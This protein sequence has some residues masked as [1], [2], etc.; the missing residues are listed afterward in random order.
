M[1]DIKCRICGEP[2][3]SYGV[4][5]SLRID[6]DGDMTA[7]EAKMLLEGRGCPSCKGIPPVYCKQK[8]EDDSALVM[9]PG[10]MDICIH[11]EKWGSKCNAPK[12][13]VCK[14]QQRSDVDHEEDFLESVTDSENADEDPIAVLSRIK[15]RK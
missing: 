5:E 12:D 10:T 8:I 7:S 11:I 13:Y 15:H 9:D 14:D 3:D 1:G 2:W 6:G 4:H